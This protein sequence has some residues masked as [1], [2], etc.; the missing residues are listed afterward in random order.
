LT[1]I[2]AVATTALLAQPELPQPSPTA[3][4]SQKVGLADVS[5]TY[6]RP[7]VKGRTIF[8]DLVPYDKIWRTGANKA[9]AIT[10]G[11][12]ATIGGKEVSAGSYSIFTI[13][14]K[15]EW[16]IIINSETELWGAGNYDEAKDVARFKVKPGKLAE[17]VESFTID[18]GSFTDEG[19]NINMSWENT[20]VS[21]P[22]GVDA[23]AQ[24]MANIEK[25]IAAV[26]GSWRV[27]VRSAQYMARTG[28]DLDKALEYTEMALAMKE[29]WWTYWVQA[30]V[31][32]AK[33]DY[34]SAIKSMKKSIKLG[35][36]I[37][38]WSYKERLEKLLAEYEAEA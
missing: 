19:C 5:I 24:A 32:A 6:S 16:T 38:G 30:E 11:T 27:Y 17:K 22:L 21:F 33:K 2:F 29:Y 26:E 31:Y 3:T 15:D 34:K 8:G 9:T 25:E 28:K 13:P 1:I 37:E 10:L 12:D 18:F 14:G 7:G 4:I 36:E 35:E 20:K 23:V